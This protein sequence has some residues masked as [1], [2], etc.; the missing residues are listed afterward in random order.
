MAT[1]VQTALPDRS[2]AIKLLGGLVV[3]VAVILIAYRQSDTPV[4]TEDVPRR[5]ITFII[6]AAAICTIYWATHANP[7]W[8]F[9]LRHIGYVVVGA[10]IYALL[11]YIGNTSEIFSIPSASQIAFRPAI[12]V[13]IVFG[14]LFGPITGLLT[15]LIGNVLGD[16]GSNFGVSPQWDLAN[17]L[18]GFVA[19][20]IVLIPAGQRRQQATWWVLGI[21]SALSVLTFIL[22]MFNQTTPNQFIFSDTPIAVSTLLGLTPIIGIGLV[23]GAYFV[24]AFVSLE[25]ATAVAW[26]GLANLVGIGFAALADIYVN[27]FAPNAAIVGEFI[28]AAGPNMMVLA[29]L[30]PIV[31]VGYQTIRSRRVDK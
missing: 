8:Q 19:G 11:L 2:V 4:D 28:P 29:V 1:R 7:A 16:L 30:V 12:V 15:G 23:I 22:F 31:I 5:W 14:Y 21:A 18:V 26:G 3:A 25:A 13:P 27:G 20:L 24:L 9:K 10:L 6:G 17:G